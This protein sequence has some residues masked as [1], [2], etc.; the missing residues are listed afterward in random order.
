MKIPEFNKYACAGD[1]VTWSAGGFDFTAQLE[2]DEDSRIE[3]SDCYS[4]KQVKA[5]KA[6]G[7]FFGGIVVSAELNGVS[8]CDYAASLWWIEVNFP[9]RRKNTNAFLSQVCQELS[10]EALNAAEK[11]LSVLREKRA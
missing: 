2:F 1:T 8:V 6:D 10:G 9:S 11:A 4:E 7:W 3:D 5:W